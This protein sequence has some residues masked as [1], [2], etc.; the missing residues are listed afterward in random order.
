MDIRTGGISVFVL[1][2]CPI[3]VW[4]WR[5]TSMTVVSGSACLCLPYGLKSIELLWHSN[6]G[7]SLHRLQLITVLWG[8]GKLQE[9]HLLIFCLLCVSQLT[10][11]FDYGLPWAIK[12]LDHQKVD[13]SCCC[14][15]C[16]ITAISALDSLQSCHFLLVFSESSGFPLYLPS[17]VPS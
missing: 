6:I 9:K 4:Q 8:S 11:G 3:C 12:I 5:V 14:L 16:H 2:D 17:S 1:S 10:E 7:Y 15:V 13:R